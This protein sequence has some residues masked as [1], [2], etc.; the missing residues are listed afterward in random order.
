[1]SKS[2]AGLTATPYSLCRYC[3]TF[4]L[5][6]CLTVWTARWK[7]AS[8][9]SD[10]SFCSS[11]RCVIQSSPICCSDPKRHGQSSEIK[12]RLLKL[13]DSKVKKNPENN[14]MVSCFMEDGPTSA[15]TSD[16]AELQRRSHRRGVIPLVLFWNLAG[17]IS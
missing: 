2:E 11:S 1:M 3:D 15:M 5:F 6:S 16:R 7:P 4:I 13:W 8:V 10:R 12:C 9:D 14:E 17:S